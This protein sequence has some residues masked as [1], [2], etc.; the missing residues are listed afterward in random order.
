MRMCTSCMTY[1]CP[2]LPRVSPLSCILTTHTHRWSIVIKNPTK[3]ASENMS[4]VKVVIGSRSI[5]KKPIALPPKTLPFLPPLTAVPTIANALRIVDH[6]KPYLP[7]LVV[8]DFNLSSFPP[9]FPG[10]GP[11]EFPAVPNYD[12][13]A[14]PPPEVPEI[15]KS[16]EIEIDPSTPPEITTDPHPV[17]RPEFPRP[18][19]PSP[20]DDPDIPLP[21][22]PPPDLF[23]PRPPDNNPPPTIP[24]DVYPPMPR[25]L[26]RL[27][28]RRR[29]FNHLWAHLGRLYFRTWF[30]GPINV[31]VQS[32]SNTWSYAQ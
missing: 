10:K 11:P 30:L 22:N 6:N 12:E 26:T 31:Y 5:V 23:P 32:A 27:L 19:I 25:I 18:P 7:S 21:H 28:R 15:T 13:P 24:P 3:I 29:I 2:P 1:T 20:P 16:P 17:T 9:E 14:F 8:F 4:L